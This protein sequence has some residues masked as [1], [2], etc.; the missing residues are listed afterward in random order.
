MPGNETGNEPTPE[1]LAAIEAMQMRAKE[2][3]AALE[4]AHEALTEALAATLNTQ[5]ALDAA[6]TAHTALTTAIAAAADVS[7]ADKAK[8]EN[9]A[10]AAMGT[11]AST[12]KV[13]DANEAEDARK[14]AEADAKALNE[15]AMKLNAAIVVSRPL[16]AA[17]RALNQWW[18]TSHMAREAVWKSSPAPFT[19]TTRTKLKPPARS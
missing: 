16:S 14:Q 18:I 19:S 9:A 4:R 7:A 1:E 13:F 6:N 3:K 12:Q 10:S 8:Y 5:E 2:Q 15:M 17:P 11:I